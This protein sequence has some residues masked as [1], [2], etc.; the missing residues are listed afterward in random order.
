[1]PSGIHHITKIAELTIHP[2]LI[3]NDVKRVRGSVQI[4][5]LSSNSEEPTLQIPFR[6]TILHGSLDYDKAAS[7]FYI[8]SSPI[9]SSNGNKEECRSIKLINRFNDSMV[10]YNVTTDKTELLS[11]YIEV[12]Y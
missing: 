5:T 6:A 11:K 9:D 3:P 2:H 8:P 1:M 7:Y 10:I 4:Y 12:N